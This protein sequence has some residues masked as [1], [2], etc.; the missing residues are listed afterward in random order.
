[1]ASFI[2]GF[3]LRIAFFVKF[4][5]DC[6]IFTFWHRLFVRT[7][8][9]PISEEERVIDV[10]ISSYSNVFHLASIFVTCVQEKLELL[11]SKLISLEKSIKN[12]KKR[13]RRSLKKVMEARSAAPLPASPPLVAPPAIASAAPP[14]PPPPPPAPKQKLQSKVCLSGDDW[15]CLLSLK[16]TACR[17]QTP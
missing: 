6:V 12:M 7:S 9:L 17:R 10:R 4:V 16:E 2:P 3:I 5:V 15:L 8:V 13:H 11:T 1:M 14:P